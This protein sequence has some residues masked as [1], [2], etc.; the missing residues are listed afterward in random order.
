MRLSIS[1][2]NLLL[3]LHRFRDIAFDRSQVAIFGYPC[4]VFSPK[5][6][7]PRTISV[8][9]CLEVSGSLRY[10]M[11]YK[12][13]GNFNRLSRTHECYRRQTDYRQTDLIWRSHVRVIK[14]YKI[15]FKA[16]GNSQEFLCA[17]FPAGIPGSFWKSA[18]GCL[19]FGKKCKI[20]TGSSA[21]A[22]SGGQALAW[23]TTL[24]L[25]SP[26]SS[27]SRPSTPPFPSPP[28]SSPLLSSPPP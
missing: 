15:G 9:F 4:C 14:I 18:T 26:I 5:R 2:T 23:G 22:S 24:P 25:P 7:S 17:E 12:H 10:Q 28:L 13:A 11:A 1:D 20:G 8:K 19:S 21:G 3:I 27:L 6:G 16:T